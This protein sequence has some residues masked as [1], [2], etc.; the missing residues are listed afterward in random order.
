MRLLSGHSRRLRGVVNNG[1]RMGA[2]SA[3][4]AACL[5]LAVGGGLSFISDALA[6]GTADPRAVR[7]AELDVL[8]DALANHNEPPTITKDSHMPLFSEKYDWGE[9]TRV[10]EACRTLVK[11]E[12]PEI[13]PRLVEHIG[14]NRYA[15]TASFDDFTENVTVGGICLE[16][17]AR[18]LEKPFHWPKTLPI[19]GSITAGKYY[20]PPW[21]HD[22][23]AWYREQHGKP[24][25]AL[26]IDVGQWGIKIIEGAKTLR[27]LT[28]ERK[29]KVI[30]KAKETINELR[31]T[32][33]PIVENHFEP[34]FERAEYF[35]TQKAEEIR[36]K[37]GA[38]R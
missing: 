15:F 3:A 26:Q 14:D 13:W 21:G 8:I 20:L 32:K 34:F 35:G 36:T 5:A 30:R 28:R 25:W 27:G 38:G 18:D 31:R 22:L 10:L 11:R 19:W 16:L 9:Q 6:D 23:K 37:Y 29:A 1:T 4:S 24:L 12:G 17:A 2:R 7:V 33:K